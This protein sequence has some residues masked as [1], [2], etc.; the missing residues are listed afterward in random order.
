M[1]LFDAT[2]RYYCEMLHFH[3][4]LQCCE[5]SPNHSLRN[6][7]CEIQ[8]LPG[9]AFSK[10]E[11][12]KAWKSNRGACRHAQRKDKTNE[13]KKNDPRNHQTTFSTCIKHS[14]FK[15]KEVYYL[16]ASSSRWKEVECTWQ[17]SSYPHQK[18][19]VEHNFFTFSNFA[20]PGGYRQLL[21]KASTI[22]VS[23]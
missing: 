8:V 12:S 4:S 5:P 2:L 10:K 21:L 18:E 20:L 9:V 1:L 15:Q 22:S 6:A 23:Q 17:P 7:F 14:G 3:T 19:F 16:Q 11:R 13:R